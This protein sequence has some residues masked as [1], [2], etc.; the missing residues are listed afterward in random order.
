MGHPTNHEMAT[1]FAISV[2]YCAFGLVVQTSRDPASEIDV[3]V[4]GRG[5][6]ALPA[7]ALLGE[8]PQRLTERRLRDIRMHAA[9]IQHKHGWDCSISVIYSGINTDS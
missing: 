2:T 3:L 7:R 6:V 8:P 9:I 5:D 4:Q 1:L